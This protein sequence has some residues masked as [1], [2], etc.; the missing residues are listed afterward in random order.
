MNATLDV[1]TGY[2]PDF[3]RNDVLAHLP[4]RSGEGIHRA[5]YDLAR[6]LTPYRTVAQ[7]EA[8]LRGY[9]AQ[10]DRHVPE[11]EIQAALADGARRAWKPNGYTVESSPQPPQPKFS[12]EVF[13]RFVA[14]APRADARQLIERSPVPVDEQT[15]AT[16]LHALYRSGEKVLIFDDLR[17]Q[18]QAVW[19]R[20]GIASH[21]GMAS[22]P[23]I[24]SATPHSL[25]HFTSGRRCGV[26]FLANPADAIFRVNDTGRLSRRSA[27]NLTAWRYLLV[28]SDRSDISPDEWLTALMR[29]ELP[30]VSIVETGGRLPHAL[31]HIGAE[32]KE[33]W[34]AKRDEL[35]PD[36]IMIGA[37]VA[38]LSGVRLT[39]LAGCERAG[40]ED[41][42]GRYHE[43]P[44]GPR[45]QRLIYLNPQ[46][47]VLS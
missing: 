21:P 29:L 14:G 42:E 19:E 33:Q 31:V 20:P 9:A 35:R 43:F 10:C 17:S 13:K 46:P 36:L 22:A 40:H 2:L 8:I 47:L 16:V 12:L 18:G 37:D 3:I 30:I 44:D 5:L 41:V 15:P 38:A 7:R 4:T 6:V 25:D 32:N 39:R 11:M 26:W 23:R 28:E 24:A 1:G 34:D 45:A 27:Q